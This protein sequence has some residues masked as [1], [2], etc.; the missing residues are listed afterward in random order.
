MQYR[1]TCNNCGRDYMVD[2]N[3]GETIHA[4]CPYCGALANVVTPADMNNVNAGVSTDTYQPIRPESYRTMRHEK[5]KN[6]KPLFLRVTMW[7]LIIITILFILLT[8]LY[9]VFTG[10]TSPK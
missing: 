7:F 5:R 9:F 2:G 10:L 8:I 1:T 3:P 6:E 4:K